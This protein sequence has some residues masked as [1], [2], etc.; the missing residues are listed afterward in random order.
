MA[1]EGTTLVRVACEA[2]AR[3]HGEDIIVHDVRGWSDVTAYMVAVTANSTPH[4]KALS[5]E[6][7]TSLKHAGR[8]CYR[9]GGEPSS[10]WVVLDFLEAVVHIFLREV[11][12]RY[13]VDQLWGQAMR[14]RSG[15]PPEPPPPP[16][17]PA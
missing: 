12:E 7:Q 9:R 13:A 17:P 16:S 11:R 8:P 1:I 15:P 5:D 14:L 2:L 10:G 6:V 3:R 4:I